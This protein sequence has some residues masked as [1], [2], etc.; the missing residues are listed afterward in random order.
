M[1]GMTREATTCKMDF[2]EELKTPI[3]NLQT[4]VSHDKGL[5]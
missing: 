2:G 3:T 1:H 5:M 4:D